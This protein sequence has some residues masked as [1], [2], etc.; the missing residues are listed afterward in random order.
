MPERVY[1]QTKRGEPITDQMIGNWRRKP[2]VATSPASSVVVVGDR[3]GHRWAR[4]QRR[5]TRC[6]WSLPFGQRPP[7][8]RKRRGRRSLR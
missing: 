4:R 8:V 1:G 5:S 6:A 2:S 3:A 7:N